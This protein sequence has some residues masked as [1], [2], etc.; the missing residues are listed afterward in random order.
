MLD[1]DYFDSCGITPKTKT[2]IIS[3]NDLDGAGPIIIGKNYFDDVKYFTVSNAAV[4]KV[5]KLVLFAPEYADRELILITDCSVVDYSVIKAIDNENK[6]GRRKIL[7]FDHHATALHLNI[8][9]WANVTQ[10]EFVSGTKLFWRFIE[11]DAFD[12]L[13]ASRFVKI[14]CL[15]EKISDWD[16]WR[17]KNVTNDDVPRKLSELFSKTGINYFLTKYVG[18]PL[19]FYFQIQG[20]KEFNLF[21]DLDNALLKDFEEKDKYLVWPKILKSARIIEIP[22][23]L[24]NEVR[25]VKCISVSDN[26]G[27]KA[28]QLYEEGVDYVFMFYSDAISIRSRVDDIDLGAWAKAIAGGGGHKRSAGFPIKKESRWIMDAYQQAKFN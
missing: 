14:D 18:S 5:V 19:D 4:D 26:P 12:V 1:K 20:T 21:T 27:D 16:T 17:W 6:N 9:E 28:E 8:Y 10:E 22:I 15:V 2:A 11:E 25:K 3:H 13:G 24:Q 7:L 23:G